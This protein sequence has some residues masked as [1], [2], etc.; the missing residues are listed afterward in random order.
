MW[1]LGMSPEKGGVMPRYWII[2]PYNAEKVETWEK[3]WKYDLEHGIITIG[4]ERLGDVSALSEAQLREA[5]DRA[6]P[7]HSP[8]QNAFVL[9][10]FRDFY[11]SI[12]PGDIVIARRGLK[13]IAGIGTVTR[14]AYY[15]KK[16]KNPEGASGKRKYS[17]CLG[18][19][20]EETPR[21]KSFDTPVFQMPA[22]REVP[23]QKY[24]ELTQAEPSASLGLPFGKSTAEGVENPA[25]FVLEK[26]LEEFI[27]SNF[28]AIFEGKLRIY[29]EPVKDDDSSESIIGQQFDTG[30][31]GIIDILAQDK[32]SNDFVVIEL[33]KGR[34]A[35]KIVGQ[36]LSYMGWVEE[37]L[38]GGGQ[39]V[40]GLIIC[41]EPDS[42]LSS[43][44]KMAK[45]VSVKY[46]RINFKLEDQPS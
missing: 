35:D 27:V 22:L 15:E 9:R 29:S 42:R 41:K 8:R 25:E 7:E 2:A 39:K 44:L 26:Y 28:P 36:V 1:L 24:L 11:H 40:R 45:N 19:R 46:Y 13:V 18:V 23:E 43:A 17:N 38:C 33:K 34:G 32:S 37:K 21:N 10:V 14:A 6:Y 16:T 5:I 20:W 12:K 3:V 4:W 31:V 30:E